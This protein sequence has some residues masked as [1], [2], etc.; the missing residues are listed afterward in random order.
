[1]KPDIEWSIL[2]LQME[3]TNKYRGHCPN[4]YNMPP[5]E[6]LDKLQAITNYMRMKNEKPDN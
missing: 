4:R 3:I 5:V 2:K 6:Y 1:M